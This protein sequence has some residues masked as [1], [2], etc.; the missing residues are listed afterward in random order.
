MNLFK[1]F[2]PKENAQTATELESW[3]VT[4]RIYS[5]WAG[6]TDQHSKVFIKEDEAKEYRRQLEE[7]AKFVRCW[8][9]TS[10][11]KN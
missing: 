3:T 9:K 11:Y 8:I 1:I 4:W 2:M 10:M 7:Q 6:A 5:G